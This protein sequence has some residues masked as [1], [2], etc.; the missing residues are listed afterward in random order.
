VALS[1][2]STYLT[3]LADRSVL[4]KVGVAHGKRYRLTTPRIESP[5][6]LT[7]DNK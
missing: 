5:V 2:V 3:R 4:S 1:M 6:S 7:K